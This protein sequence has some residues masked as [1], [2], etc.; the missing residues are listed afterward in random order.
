LEGVMF[1]DDAVEALG[2]FVLELCD[3]CYRKARELCF[4]RRGPKL[5]KREKARTLGL[6]GI[7][8]AF[9]SS[10]CSDQERPRTTK[11]DHERP[12]ARSDEERPV[13]FFWKLP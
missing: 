11:S 13:N 7:S 1:N 9:Q 6:K 10:T 8:L 5:L 4:V 3:Y 12:G 2:D